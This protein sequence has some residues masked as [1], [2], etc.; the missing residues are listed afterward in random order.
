MRCVVL[1]VLTSVLV[2]PVLA[3][4]EEAR[5]EVV[6]IKRNPTAI[7]EAMSRMQPPRYTGIGVT[8]LRLLTMGFLPITD[9]IEGAPAWFSTER[10]DVQATWSGPT[11][12]LR[13]RAMMRNL[14][15]DAFKVKSH[16]EMRD[17]PAYALVLARSDRRVGPQLK[18]AAV[19]D[20]LA[21][22]A[23]TGAAVPASLQACGM[24]GGNS[25]RGGV[26][27]KGTSASMERLARE[28]S[29]TGRPVVDRTGL[30]GTYDFELEFS[31]AAT[32]DAQLPSV[33]TALQEQ[34]GLK[35]EAT[36][37]PVRVL[38]IDAVDRP[39]EN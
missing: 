14:V 39:T 1:T 11:E 31:P 22:N 8:G 35:L 18:V 21:A 24:R 5:F 16:L 20:C 9:R 19:P 33:F 12:D 3:Q 30:P 34:L 23:A 2:V 10:Y 13:L 38:V 25:P 4:V 15:I 7:E 27:L 28:L 29:L 26:A 6:S 36:T 17:V 37:A 32:P